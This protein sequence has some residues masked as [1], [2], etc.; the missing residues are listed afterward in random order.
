[1]TDQRLYRNSRKGGLVKKC[2]K[3]GLEKPLDG[4]YCDRKNSD[5]KSV[6]CKACKQEYVKQNKKEIVKYQREYYH[7]NREMCMKK[8][9]DWIKN[10][11]DKVREYY[12]KYD[13]RNKEISEAYQSLNIH[14]ISFSEFRRDWLNSNKH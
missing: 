10:N 3:C 4:F 12:K 9:R 6:R 2:S 7:K 1:M 8:T 5:G 14:G 11:R 13:A